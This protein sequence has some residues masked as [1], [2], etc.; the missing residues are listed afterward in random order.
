MIHTVRGKIHKKDMGMTLGHEHFNW[1]E[2][3]LFTSAMYFEKVYD[4]AYNKKMFNQLM[5]ILEGLKEVR[6]QTIVEASP[7]LG[8]QNL[9]LLYDLS[10]ESKINIIPCTGINVTKF[11]YEI[12]KEGFVDQLSKRWISDFENGLDT[13]DGICIKPAYIKLLLDKG[14]LS[15]VD[16]AMVRA[17]AIASN[18]TGMPI[19]CHIL[20]ANRVAPVLKI[21]KDMDLP[22]KKFLWAHA[23]KEGNLE[24]ILEVVKQGY[25]VGFDMIREG[26]YENRKSLLDH[27]IKHAYTDQV[28]LSQDYD[29]Y[30]EIQNQNPIEICGS[31]F[32]KF[33]PYCMDAG[34][35]KERLESMMTENPGRFYDIY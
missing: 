18:E 34:I 14:P 8:G 1:I 27:A 4:Q 26:T 29:F 10:K 31:I 19:H 30:E 35:S 2:D 16:Q 28:L 21:L 24:V 20:E 15:D 12:F 22:P 25:W 33:L 7:P 23:D 13:I 3:K 6:C 9:K 32:T 11:A 17:A 5:P